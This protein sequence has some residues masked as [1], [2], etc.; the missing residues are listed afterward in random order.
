MATFWANLD[1]GIFYIKYVLVTY[2]KF[3]LLFIPTSGHTDDF[4]V[5][6]YLPRFAQDQLT[7]SHQIS[8]SHFRFHQI[9]S[10]IVITYQISSYILFSHQKLSDLIRFHQNSWDF[11]IS[12]ILSSDLIKSQQIPSVLIRSDQ[13]SWCPIRSYQ[14]QPDLI[15]SHQILSY[16]VFSHQISSDSFRSR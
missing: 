6:T 10:D 3:G 5:P 2:D 9:P 1:N 16:L 12:L 14:I 11:V 8:S 4:S 15:N 7:A 13:I